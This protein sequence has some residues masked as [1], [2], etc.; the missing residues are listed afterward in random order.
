MINLRW[1][2]KK[3]LEFI[4]ARLFWKGVINR[5]D[6]TTFFQISIPQASSDL[7]IYQEQAPRNIKYDKS[8]KC[9]YATDKFFPKFLGSDPAALL[10][11]LRFSQ[12]IQQDDSQ[13]QIVGIPECYVVPTPERN[14]DFNI[15]KQ[16][17]Q[18]INQEKDIEIEYQSMTR[19]EASCRWISPHAFA[20]DGFRWH[21]RALCQERRQYI[22]FVLG[23]ILTIKGNKKRDIGIPEDI[24]WNTYVVLKVAPHPGLT[25][26]QTKIIEREFGM[27]NGYTE[28]KVKKAVLFYTKILL[29]LDDGHK[30]RDAKTQ[31]IILLDEKDTK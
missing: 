19:P 30:D 10:D 8:N 20:F 15:L 3:R 7:Q 14:L 21:V 24:E 5:K 26:Q 11:Q 29:R 31:Q 18:A 17:S 12:N 2:V 27:I 1:G 16:V 13:S 28:I 6:L 4:E 23:R 22:D 9:Y 25:P